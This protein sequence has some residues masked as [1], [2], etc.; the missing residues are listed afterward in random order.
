MKRLMLFAVVIGA[1]G[2]RENAA[3]DSAGMTAATAPAALTPADI[4]G[5]WNGVTMMETGDS[6][7]ARW[8]VINPTGTEGKGVFEG[9]TDTLTLSHTF[10]ADSFVA[11]T[12][13]YR[14]PN[15]P[16]R[17]QVTTR[18]VGRL[19][20]GKLLG[21]STTMLVSKPDSVVMRNR[22]EATKAQ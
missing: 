8:T 22:W 19:V 13:P 14:D 21:T 6:V 11:T 10:D 5:T 16:G 7:L 20:A 3:T 9:S 15:L 17:P 12:T 2:P 4:A 18:A 1:C